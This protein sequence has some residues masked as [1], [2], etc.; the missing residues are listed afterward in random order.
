MF[1]TTA[2]IAV[3]HLLF[4][5]LLVIAPVWDFY[6][7][8]RLKRSPSSAGK[9]R[10]YKTLCAWLWIASGVAYLAVGF[11]PL[12]TIS[13]APGEVSWLFDHS[14]VRC[15]VEIAIGLFGA[16]MLLPVA[17]VVRKKLKNEP[18]KYSSADAMKSLDYFFPATWIERRWFA[19]LCITAGVCE[20]TLFRGFL[21]H[22][23][24]VIPGT[25]N[26]TL[27]LLGS[28]AIFGLNHL[29]TGASGVLANI[30]VGFLIGLLFLL[31]GNLLIPMV[32][33]AIMDLRM[34]VILRPPS[35]D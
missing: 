15:L 11:R 19:F 10:Y 4:L 5:F 3:Q 9:I 2:S 31:T 25:F 27:A 28:S 32:F 29:Y 7:T 34:L 18:R 12:L 24:H 22:Y 8:S 14:W 13:P 33:H 1:N 21:L 23:F 17:M 20:E 35:D 6:D 30:V 16:V 26:L